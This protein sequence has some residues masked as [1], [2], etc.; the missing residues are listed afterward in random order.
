M[1]VIQLASFAAMIPT[2]LKTKRPLPKSLTPDHFQYQFLPC[3]RCKRLIIVSPPELTL[4]SYTSN[5]SNLHPHPPPF[6]Q[7]VPRRIHDQRISRHK[8]HSVA[9]SSMP[10]H[11]QHCL[12]IWHLQF[13]CFYFS[14]SPFMPIC[15]ESSRHIS[16]SS[17]DIHPT[18][19]S[20]PPSNSIKQN[21]TKKN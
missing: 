8:W 2:Q 20:S 13:T 12:A 5:T 18:Q 14:L 11:C 21:K 6:D 1:Q 19:P 7:S 4:K 16:P 3:R 9:G 10:L 17:T 15:V